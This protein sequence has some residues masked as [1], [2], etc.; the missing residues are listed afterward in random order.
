MQAS[1]GTGGHA[2]TV[3]ISGGV[4]VT[5]SATAA[6]GLQCQA[7]LAATP[8]L[9]NYLTH[10]TATAAEVAAVTSGSLT[11]TGVPGAPLNYVFVETVTAGGCLDIWFNPPLPATDVDVAITV[12]I[13]AIAGGSNTAI[14]VTGWQA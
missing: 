2:L 4:E 9:M 10:F 3:P 5:G 6:A 14:T 12:T 1:A 11:V 7:S 13:A 8:G